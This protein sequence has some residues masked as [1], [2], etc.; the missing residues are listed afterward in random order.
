[1]TTTKWGLDAAHSEINF[2]VKHMMIANVSGNFT[3]FNVNAET[4][5]D[6]FSKAKINFTADTA[7]IYT[8]NEQRDGHLKSPDF[9]DAEK[10]PQLKFESDSITK[11]SD[12]EYVMN[13]NLTIKDVTKPV[14]LN[15]NFG[16][17]GKDPYGNTKAGFTVEGKINR[18]DFGLTWNA[19]LETGGMLV[20]EDL[21]IHSEI[22]LAKQA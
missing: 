18:K 10:F 7:S 16:G 2:K 9:F 21:K 12:D 1:M 22:Q 19:A 5:G 20:G 4:E 13:G 17:I 14:A 11:K 3:K 8:N 6:D 15:L